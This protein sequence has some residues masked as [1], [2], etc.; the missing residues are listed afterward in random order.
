[1]VI[2]KTEITTF[3]SEYNKCKSCYKKSL[4]CDVSKNVLKISK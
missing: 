1:M 2:N 3:I 4:T